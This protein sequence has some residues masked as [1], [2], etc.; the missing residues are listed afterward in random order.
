[1][2]PDVPNGIITQYELQYRRSNDASWNIYNM[3]SRTLG[4]RLFGST[5]SLLPDIEYLL[6]I[7]AYTRAGAGPLGSTLTTSVVSNCKLLFYL[8]LHKRLGEATYFY[9]HNKTYIA[10]QLS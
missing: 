9:C 5:G 7:R 6:R 3:S 8:Y 1:M 2:A 10:S 4:N